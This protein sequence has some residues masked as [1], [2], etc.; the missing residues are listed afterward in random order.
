MF[1]FEWIVGK[2]FEKQRDWALGHLSR[3]D[4]FV[5]SVAQDVGPCFIF[6]KSFFRAAAGFS[7]V[8]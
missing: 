6:D 3:T 5:F 1:F 4:S 8:S 2:G 7:T